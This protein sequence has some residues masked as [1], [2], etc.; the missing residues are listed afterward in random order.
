[1]PLEETIVDHFESQADRTPGALALVA[2]GE[3]LTFGA[4]DARANRLANHLKKLGAGP[5][6]VVGMCLPRS[7]DVIVALLGILKAGAAYL[8]L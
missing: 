1:M 5:D 3:R 8:L 4:L 7:A 6:V 2:S